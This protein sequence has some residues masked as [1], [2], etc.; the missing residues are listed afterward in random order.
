[1]RRW[2]FAWAWTIGVVLT[3]C[4]CLGR[5]EQ[6]TVANAAIPDPVRTAVGSACATTGV[7]L[8]EYDESG[9]Y[10]VLA[11]KDGAW[12]IIPGV[13]VRKVVVAKAK[14]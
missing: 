7:L 8:V 13:V 14:R 10:R 9:A 5:Q 2:I 12:I 11:C 6:A 1:M 3:C 4:A